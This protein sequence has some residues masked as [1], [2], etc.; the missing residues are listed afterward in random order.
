MNA[1]RLSGIKAC[2]FDAYGT[3]FNYASAV[4]GCK[5]ILGD[6][7]NPLN[8]IWREKQLQYTWLRSLQGRYVD[9]W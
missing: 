7:L 9:F 8:A 1:T 3:L 4:A 6:N 5:D 2:V